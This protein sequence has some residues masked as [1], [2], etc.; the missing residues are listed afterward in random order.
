MTT[1]VRRRA[2]ARLGMNT[3]R[4]IIRVGRRGRSPRR[5]GRTLP[6]PPLRIPFVEMEPPR[7]IVMAGRSG[8]YNRIKTL[9]VFE[10]ADAGDGT[11]EVRA[12]IET[13]PPL[14]TDK[15]MEAVWESRPTRRG[16]GP[17][18]SSP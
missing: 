8:K 11:T 15:V 2:E 14:P 7:L 12:T 1:A 13:R 16:S 3:M 9:W 18:P 5:P 10:L 4:T 17:R 6:P